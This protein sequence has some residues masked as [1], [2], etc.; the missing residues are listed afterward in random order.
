MKRLVMICLLLAAAAMPV[1]IASAQTDWRGPKELAD[2][3]ALKY[4]LA[5]GTLTTLTDA[6]YNLIMNWHGSGPAPAAAHVVEL[7]E[8]SLR[9]FHEAVK[10][11][12]CNWALVK[13][14]PGTEMPHL[15]KVRELARRACFRARYRAAT[16]DGNGAV[17]YSGRLRAF[18]T[19]QRR[20]F[21]DRLSRAACDPAPRHERGRG[22]ART[23]EPRAAREARRGA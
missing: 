15:A 4:W 19:L 8:T 20:L 16:G 18:E 12:W 3:A 21:A 1:S 9:M 14:G 6:D 23:P 2:N 13:A 11:K 10:C 22:Y 5:F 7:C 17:G